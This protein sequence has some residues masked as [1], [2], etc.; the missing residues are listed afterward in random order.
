MNY[1]TVQITVPEGVVPYLVDDGQGGPFD[2]D[3]MLLYPL[4]RNATISHGRAAEILGVCKTELIEFYDSI[5]IAFLDQSEA[6][7]FEDLQ[8]LAAVVGARA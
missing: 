2:R 4:I 8:T 7:L 6:E 3:A 1:A 5:G